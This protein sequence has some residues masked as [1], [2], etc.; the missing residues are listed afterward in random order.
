MPTT[1]S[2]GS[3]CPNPS[4]SVPFLK[5][6]GIKLE[7]VFRSVDLSIATFRR[8]IS[9]VI[10]EMTRVALLTKQD[11][12]VKEDPSFA[13][14]KFLYNLKRAHYEKEWGKS[15]QKPGVGARILAVMFKLIPKVLQG[16]RLQ[17]AKSGDRNPLSEEM[18]S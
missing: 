14:K 4:W 15:Y 11:E 7:D 9:T 13:K 3:R 16:N 1:T 6:Y 2:L 18:V 12:L 17:N 8:S 10:P 5:T